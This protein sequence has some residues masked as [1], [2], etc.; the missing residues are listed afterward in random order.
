MTRY[1]PSSWRTSA[2]NGRALYAEAM[3][4][5]YAPAWPIV[6]RSPGSGSGQLE[7]EREEVARLAH[8]ADHVHLPGRPVVAPPPRTAMGWLAPYSAGRIRSFMP[9]SQMA[10]R[11]PGTSFT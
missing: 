1:S 5:P 3:T 7:V 8:R 10:I 2:Q 6:T 9:P 4:R 11:R